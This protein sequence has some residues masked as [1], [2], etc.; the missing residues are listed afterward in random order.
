MRLIDRMR[1]APRPR[2]D[3]P[4][5]SRAFEDDPHGRFWWHKLPGTGYVP[6]LYAQLS[7]EE[8]ALMEA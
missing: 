1:R 6:P 3:G 8:W 2:T 7:D 5:R 4:P